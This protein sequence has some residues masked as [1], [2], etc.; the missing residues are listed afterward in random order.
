MNKIAFVLSLI[1]LCAVFYYL[2]SLIEKIDQSELALNRL[3]RTTLSHVNFIDRRLVKSED[4]F[5]KKHIVGHFCSAANLAEGIIFRKNKTFM[6]YDREGSAEGTY[7]ISKRGL[8]ELISNY[9]E[10]NDWQMLPYL[11]KQDNGKEM[12]H[13]LSIYSNKTSYSKLNCK[14]KYKEKYK[15]KQ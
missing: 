6:L 7:D 2:N 3:R 13:I 8:T 11:V 9:S 12:E 14:G 15:G 4:I 1:S 5:D 10:I